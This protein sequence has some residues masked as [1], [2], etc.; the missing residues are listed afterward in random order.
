MEVSFDVN[1]EVK[2]MYKF[3][4][5]NVYRKATGIIWVIF[6]LVVIGVTVYTWGDVDYAYSALMILLAALYTVINPVMLYFK[7][8]RQ[9]KRTDAFKD[10]LRYTVDGEGVKISQG[11][12]SA[13]ASWEDMWKAVRYGSQIVLYANAVS[14]F[15][16]P[17]R[18]IE[19][20]DGLV[21]IM[22]EHMG[23]RCRVRKKTE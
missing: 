5:N 4:L 16:W 10:T 20:Y 12:A 7:A 1:I 11:E 15:I 14:A 21:D 8:R 9:I 13:E 19:N 6:S 18:C 22:Q 2:D 17:L 3:L 23:E